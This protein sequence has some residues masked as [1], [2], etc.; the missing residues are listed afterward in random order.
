MRAKR[1]CGI[2]GL[3][4]CL[5]HLPVKHLVTGKTYYLLLLPA[6][7]TRE[8]LNPEECRIRANRAMHRQIAEHCVKFRVRRH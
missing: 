5:D 4:G 1:P 2:C 8:F 3:R 7:L 6:S